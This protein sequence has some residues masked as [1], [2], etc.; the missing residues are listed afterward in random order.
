VGAVVEVL[1]LLE[2]HGRLHR[3]ERREEWE[4]EAVVHLDPDVPPNS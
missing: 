4:E 3:K 1:L 2:V